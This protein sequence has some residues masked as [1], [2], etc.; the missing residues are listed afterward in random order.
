[1]RFTE[2]DARPVGT[3]VFAVLH[4]WQFYND[5]WDSTQE[6]ITAVFRTRERA[7]AECA[8]LTGEAAEKRARELEEHQARLTAGA[9]DEPFEDH[10]RQYKVIELELE[11]LP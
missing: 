6:D 11:G 1:V 5:N 8:R 7:E 2:V 9:E 10:P 3:K 4:V